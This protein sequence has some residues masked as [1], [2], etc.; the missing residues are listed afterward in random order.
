MMALKIMQERPKLGKII[1]S[2]KRRKEQK[3]TLIRLKLNI[4]KHAKECP[5][6]SSRLAK[7]RP[8][9]AKIISNK[10]MSLALR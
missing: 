3:Y 2:N 4:A 8:K 6:I 10:D 5:C 1:Y 7:V 9:V